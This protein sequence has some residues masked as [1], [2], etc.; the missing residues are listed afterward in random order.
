MILIGSLSLII[1]I[2]LS[3][4][5]LRRRDY[6][7]W[8]LDLRK[9][10]PFAENPT[11]K[12]KEHYEVN[13]EAYLKNYGKIIQ[14]HRTSNEEELLEYISNN[15]RLQKGQTILDAGCGFGG[16]SI[17]FAQKFEATVE[18]LTLS[19]SQA[20][21]M[22]KAIEQSKLDNTVNVQ[23][24]DFHQLDKYYKTDNFD[25]I[26]FLESLGHAGNITTV[27]R[28]ANKVLKPGGMIYIK[29]FVKRELPNSAYDKEQIIGLKEMS[30]KFRY[31]TLD[32]YHTIFTLRNEGFDLV[33]IKEP[34]FITD[35][36]EVNKSFAL[37]TGIVVGRP[38]SFGVKWKYEYPPYVDPI[39]FLFEKREYK[40]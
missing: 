33:S 18:G 6:R 21:T 26:L 39:E 20:D 31:N 24:G 9:V 36:Y 5:F 4:L 11:S 27:I 1:L 29:D 2:T 38:E 32:I 7:I 16:P 25:R 15:A 17:H 37:E 28:S 23:E 10:L 30:E 14:A 35:N 13:Q 8:Y 12:V 34:Q 19:A 40:I 22:R 3:I